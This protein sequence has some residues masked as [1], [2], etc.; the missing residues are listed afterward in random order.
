[1]RSRLFFWYFENSDNTIKKEK[2]LPKE[3]R[4]S[5][6]SRLKKGLSSSKMQSHARR[7]GYRDIK[8]LRRAEE[9]EAISKIKLNEEK[10]ERERMVC[11]KF[12]KI[13]M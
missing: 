7:N 3:H 4:R 2:V 10:E 5:V 8:Q 1:M 6:M 11:S 9:R 13:E 12:E